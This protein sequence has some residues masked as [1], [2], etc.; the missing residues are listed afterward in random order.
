[1]IKLCC[2]SS[3][4]WVSRYKRLRKLQVGRSA[5]SKPGSKSDFYGLQLWVSEIEP[6]SGHI[7]S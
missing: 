2:K 6:G 1:M 3:V 4:L 7:L 5:V